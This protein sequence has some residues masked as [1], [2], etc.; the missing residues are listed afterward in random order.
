[1]LKNMLIYF[2]SILLLIIEYLKKLY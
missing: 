2:L 1:M